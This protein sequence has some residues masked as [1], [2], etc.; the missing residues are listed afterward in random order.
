MISMK[1][2]I[3]LAGCAGML[4]TSVCFAEVTVNG[5]TISDAQ[6]NLLVKERTAQ[7]QPDS[8]EL[9][10]AMREDLIAREVVSQEAKKRGLDKNPDVVAQMQIASQSVLVRAYLQDYIKKHPVSESALKAEF[11][12]IKAAMG[13][14]EYQARHILVASEA[15]AKSIAAQLKKGAKFDKLA[16]EKSQDPGSKARGGELG[17]ITRG[18]VVPQFGDTLAKLK[19]GETSE[20]VQTQFGWHIIKLED[21]RPLKTPPFDNVKDSLRQRLEQQEIQSAVADLRKQAK[22]EGADK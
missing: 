7:G 13:D 10:K 16:S 8:P 1:S 15:E 11:E 3:L 6:V 19:K 5:V 22:V 21:V 2:R 12:R 17:W 20:P 14:T 4:S 18:N 9:R